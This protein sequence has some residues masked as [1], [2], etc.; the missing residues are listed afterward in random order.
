MTQ[1]EDF[2]QSA[3][4]GAN[5]RQNSIH[6][7]ADPWDQLVFITPALRP[8]VPAADEPLRAVVGALIL[9]LFLRTWKPGLLHAHMC[10]SLLR[11][12]RR[13]VKAS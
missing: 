5:R 1:F 11:R 6:S 4:D 10:A 12:H 9:G 7:A 2:L 3:I 13:G 8:P